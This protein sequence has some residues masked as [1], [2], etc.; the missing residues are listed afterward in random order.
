MKNSNELLRNI[1]VVVSAQNAGQLA[2]YAPAKSLSDNDR[3]T[4]A[5]WGPA[6]RR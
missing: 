3:E 1:E 4:Q 6:M 2:G 5:S